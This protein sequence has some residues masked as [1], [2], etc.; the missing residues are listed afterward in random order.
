MQ[1]S[2][3]RNTISFVAVAALLGLGACST[4]SD[5]PDQTTGD[6]ATTATTPSEGAPK[7]TSGRTA[8]A[9]TAVV[10]AAEHL[11]GIAYDIDTDDGRWEVDVFHG[12][13]STEVTLD[14]NGKD[15][16]GTERNRAPSSW[17]RE[18]LP[19]VKI[20]LA[21]A[22]S[23]ASAEVDGEFD[24]AEFERFQQT[25]VWSVNFD[26]NDGDFEVYVDANSGEVLKVERD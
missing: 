2:K 23:I 4:E 6:T 22:I 1:S 24:E 15:V 9:Q 21:D 3:L 16:I 25:P 17:L 19:A 5:V 7:E 11:S 18:N 12:G 20:S 10:T 8:L 13:D 26:S 14:P